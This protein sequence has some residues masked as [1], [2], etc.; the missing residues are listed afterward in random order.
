MPPDFVVHIH[1][2]CLFSVTTSFGA[3]TPVG[4]AAAITASS[5]LGPSAVLALGR[6][7][8]ADEGVVN[9]EGLFEKFGAVEVL[10]GFAR[11]GES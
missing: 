6:W 4:T 3:A 11:F 5:A 9:V 7:R 8:W 2:K 10:N 1:K